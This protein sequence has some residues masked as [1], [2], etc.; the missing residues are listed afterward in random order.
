MWSLTVL[1]TP[2]LGLHDHSWP[3]FAKVFGPILLGGPWETAAFHLFLW[4]GATMTPHQSCC[5]QTP[6]LIHKKHVFLGQQLRPC[7]PLPASPPHSEVQHSVLPLEPTGE[8]QT[9]VHCVPH[10]AEDTFEPLWA[11]PLTSLS[12]DFWW[13]EAHYLS[14]RRNR[15]PSCMNNAPR[16]KTLHQINNSEHL[17]GQVRVT[18]MILDHLLP[19]CYLGGQAFHFGMW[20]WPSS[21]N[22]G[23]SAVADT[24]L[25][26]Y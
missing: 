9:P 5:G 13:K 8:G 7:K 17:G 2:M 15:L 14:E 25:V 16:K 26:L 19:K 10:T 12:T 4:A 6:L 20:T 1:F 22:L 11:V 3:L 24:K 21:F 23:A 18:R